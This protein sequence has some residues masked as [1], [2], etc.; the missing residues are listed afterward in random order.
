MTAPIAATQ[1]L[2]F[3]IPGLDFTVEG[4]PL[5]ISTPLTRPFFDA[6]RE[7]R[8]LAQRCPR[9]GFFFFPRWR[10]PCCLEDDWSW[11]PLS[12]VATVVSFM[13]D[14]VGMVPAFKKDAPYGVAMFS[15]EDDIRMAGR[16][17]GDL[18]WL[19]IGAKARARPVPRGELVIF[20]F[21]AA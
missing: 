7:G 13:I 9:K 5:P 20:E 6:A 12:G 11:E 16:V 18:S 3:I 10:C 14:R 1:G 4:E 8:L 2:P 19:A 15:L 21:E 17:R